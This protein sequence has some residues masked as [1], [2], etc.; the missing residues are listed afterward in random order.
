VVPADWRAQLK[1]LGCVGFHA[2]AEDNDLELLRDCRRHGVQMAIWTVNDAHQAA[3][4]FAAGMDAV[5]SD[6]PDLFPAS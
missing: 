3:R 6:R 1:A 4:L 2:S 5:F